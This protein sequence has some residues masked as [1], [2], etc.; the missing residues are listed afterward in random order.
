MLHV[1]TRLVFGFVTRNECVAF[2]GFSS[3]WTTSSSEME[4]S[5]AALAALGILIQ[6]SVQQKVLRTVW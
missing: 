2:F 4:N 5:W 6:L 3:S 1:V